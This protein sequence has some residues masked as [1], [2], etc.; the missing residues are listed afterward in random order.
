MYSDVAAE[1]WSYMSAGIR[2]DRIYSVS[3]WADAHRILP[4]S[5]SSEHGPWR[6]SRVPYL[7][8]IMDA[9]SPSSPWRTVVLMKGSQVGGSECGFNWIGFTIDVSPAATMIVMPTKELMETTSKMRIDPMIDAC[10]SLRRKVSEA[11]SRDSN[12]TMRMKAFPGGLLAMVGANATSGLRSL[13]ISKLMMDEVDDYPVNVRGQG[14]VVTL[15]KA[16]T[17]TFKDAK[18]FIC[19]SPTLAGTSRIEPAYDNTQKM[20]LYVPCPHCGGYQVL[21]WSQIKWD[22]GAPEKAWYVCEFCSACIQN[23]EK[24]EMLARYEWRPD[25]PDY[26]GDSI[27]FHLPSFYSPVGMYSWGQIAVDWVEAGHDENKLKAIKNTVFGETW[28]PIGEV[29]EWELLFKRREEYARNEV[30]GGG[31]FLTA[32]A[33]VQQ[34]RI[35]AEVVAWGRGKESWSVD[36]L[37]FPGD[38]SD[39][40]GPAWKALDQLLDSSF[41][42]E[43]GMSL[44]IR[45]LAIDSSYNTQ[46]VYNWCRKHS[47]DRVIPV[48]GMSSLPVLIG[49]PKAV[50]V[51]QGGRRRRKG[52]QLWGVGVDIAKTELYGWLRMSKPEGGAAAPG[53][54]HFPATYEEEW[55]RQLTGEQLQQRVVRGG[56]MTYEWVK[57]RDRN[58]AL[59][60]RVYARAAASMKGID[61][62]EPKHWAI[63]ETAIWGDRA[64]K[65][66][67]EV[68]PENATPTSK[69]ARSGRP[70]RGRRQISSGVKL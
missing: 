8:D 63:L 68:Q 26:H 10:P 14:D 28:K 41:Q 47:M 15:A 13:P 24:T 70:Y 44:T 29:P 37:V 46:G 9:L 40:N 66:V 59:D 49:Q 23:H 16:R 64:P 56:R 33:D 43:S 27:G 69:P 22:K 20:R 39:E 55:F 30:P 52:I 65:I 58:E 21:K 61:K 38:T 18:I 36:E 4:A 19:S 57:I 6:T 17:R 31:L 34:D 62:F 35:H 12:N 54:C 2:P 25:V 53:Y 3:E 48:K 5:T 11:K 42:H 60:T 51:Y 1:L 67:D 45:C 50:D 7:K 32:G